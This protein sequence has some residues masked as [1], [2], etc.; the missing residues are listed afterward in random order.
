VIAEGIRANV[1]VMNRS[2]WQK[3]EL[4]RS[5]SRERD[6]PVLL[7]GARIEFREDLSRIRKSRRIQPNAEG[8]HSR[9]MCLGPEGTE[10]RS[11]AR[12]E[13]RSFSL[14]EFPEHV[15]ILIR[16]ALL[17]GS[18]RRGTRLMIPSIRARK[19]DVT[20]RILLPRQER[21]LTVGRLLAPDA[22]GRSFDR[23]LTG[24]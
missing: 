2:R 6:A 24:V 5:G 21:V 8:A 9:Y 7:L 10:L 11:R 14:F 16:G 12:G 1:T 23:P 4:E 18:R 3:Q 15:G 13:G 22:R 20:R 17:Y 19:G